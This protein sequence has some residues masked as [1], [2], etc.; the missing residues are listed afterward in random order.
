[1][2]TPFRLT[3]DRFVGLLDQMV[4]GLSGLFNKPRCYIT[5]FKLNIKPKRLA[6]AQRAGGAEMK[7]IRIKV[8]K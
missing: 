6:W 2:I 7:R 5:D 3:P 8:F 1:M 4:Q